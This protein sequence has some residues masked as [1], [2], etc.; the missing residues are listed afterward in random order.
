[1]L[2]DTEVGELWGANVE[3]GSH[4]AIGDG[5]WDHTIFRRAHQNASHLISQGLDPLTIVID[6][7]SRSPEQHGHT[8]S[9]DIAATAGCAVLIQTRSA[10]AV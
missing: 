4:P 9:S 5:G 3:D 8:V 6:R 7:M 2:H 10:A 1:M